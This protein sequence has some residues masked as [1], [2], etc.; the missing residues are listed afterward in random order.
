[1]EVRFAFAIFCF[2]RV[3]HM[4]WALSLALDSR[5]R[6]IRG[7]GQRNYVHGSP[8]AMAE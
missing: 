7:A 5:D 8:E 1:M 3:G 2:A 6:D 4:A